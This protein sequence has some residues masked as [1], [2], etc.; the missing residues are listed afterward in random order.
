NGI[1]CNGILF[2]WR[3]TDNEMLR[4]NRKHYLQIYLSGEGCLTPF[5]NYSSLVQR[6]IQNGSLVPLHEPLYLCDLMFEC[7]RDFLCVS[8]LV[9]VQFLPELSDLLVV[10]ETQ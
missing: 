9:L 2:Q 5:S 3:H 4:H 8:F 10:L 7:V 1:P 6:G